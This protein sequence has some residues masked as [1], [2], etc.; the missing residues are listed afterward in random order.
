[1]QAPESKQ[2]EGRMRFVPYWMS[3][4]AT[5]V[6]EPAAIA[7]RGTTLRGGELSCCSALVS[8]F[9]A[10]FAAGLGFAIKRGC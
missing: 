1:M 8:H 7:L 6:V 9:L 3:G 5:Q 10:E 2:A 4:V